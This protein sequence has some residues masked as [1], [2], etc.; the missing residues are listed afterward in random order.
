M[1][2]DI[3]RTRAYYDSIG[4][5]NLCDCA[6]CR[7]FYRIVQSRCPELTAFLAQYGADAAK[8]LEAVWWEEGGPEHMT[9]APM[10]VLCGSVPPDWHITLDGAEIRVTHSFPTPAGAEAP[11]FVLDAGPFPLDWALDEPY[12]ET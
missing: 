2:V 3:P 1:T 5:G 6:P 9:Y 7:N 4:E 8:P 10:Y 12:P 11:F